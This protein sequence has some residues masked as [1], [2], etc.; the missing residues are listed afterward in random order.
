[1]SVTEKAS[2]WLNEVGKTKHKELYDKVVTNNENEKLS[3]IEIVFRMFNE[4]PSLIQEMFSYV[5]SSVPP[6]TISD[7]EPISPEK[8]EA[9]ASSAIDDSIV[10]SNSPSVSSDVDITPSENKPTEIVA[11]KEKQDDVNNEEGGEEEEESTVV[12]PYV[13]DQAP[14]LPPRDESNVGINPGGEIDISPQS[15]EIPPA[16]LRPMTPKKAVSF[17]RPLTMEKFI[18]DKPIEPIVIVPTQEQQKEETE[19]NKGESNVKETT[20]KESVI[21]DPKQGTIVT[22][23]PECTII[24]KAVENPVFSTKISE[25]VIRNSSGTVTQTKITKTIEPIQETT[26]LD[27]KRVVLQKTEIVEPQVKV[28]EIDVSSNEPLKQVEPIVSVPVSPSLPLE[29]VTPQIPIR[30]QT[31][32]QP[33]ELPPRN[34][35]ISI[36]VENPTPIEEPVKLEEAVK[37]P[38]LPPRNPPISIVLTD[39]VSNDE[40][41]KID[42]ELV[43]EQKSFKEQTKKQETGEFQTNGPPIVWIRNEEGNNSCLVNYLFVIIQSELK[44]ILLSRAWESKVKDLLS[45]NPNETFGCSSFDRETFGTDSPTNFVE[46]L[47]KF[48]AKY[49]V[50]Q[51]QKLTVVYPRIK[52]GRRKIES[53]DPWMVVT[54]AKSDGSLQ[55]ESSLFPGEEIE[56]IAIPYFCF[57]AVDRSKNGN[58][59]AFPPERLNN[60]YSS[61]LERPI[62]L[63][64]LLTKDENNNNKYSLFLNLNRKYYEYSYPS[65][66]PLGSYSYDDLLDLNLGSKAVLFLYRS[67]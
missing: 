14:A 32:S 64:A 10:T 56:T 43:K 20:C 48:F 11:E 26:S 36:I 38:E 15:P 13:S 55:V 60:G 27:P 62:H 46:I 66:E 25:S 45:K 4:D 44:K 29:P 37:P 23:A 53:R 40:M 57:F 33:P 8:I 9:E 30:E 18:E 67:V 24:T 5:P 21:V 54:G 59:N 2:I 7:P 35:P 1:M 51:E 31:L 50:S 49:S 22:S 28:Q 41:K 3:D 47:S 63:A 17:K 12:V 65:T 39:M 34:P 42:E 58:F 61:E 19:L 6:Q 52:L 16:P